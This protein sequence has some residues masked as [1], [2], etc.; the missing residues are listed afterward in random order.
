ML[1]LNITEMERDFTTVKVVTDS[2]SDIPADVAAELGI[3]V[4]PCNV[5]FGQ[6]V[7]RDGIDLTNEEFYSRLVASSELPTTSQPSAGV[8]E[9]TYRRLGSDGAAILSIHIPARVS[10]TL[11]SAHIARQALPDLSIAVVDSTQISMALGWLVIKAARAARE[12]MN[13]NRILEMVNATIPRLRLLA[14]LETLEYVYRGGR[15]G[16]AQAL[17]GT[18]LKVK[19]VIQVLNGEV[20]PIENVRTKRKALRRLIELVQALGPLEEVA[21]IHSSNAAGAREVRQMMASLHPVERIPVVEAGPVL[22]THAG[23]GAVG[24]ACVLAE[25]RRA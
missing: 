4:V 17:M 2:I 1:V 19:P 9:E 13:M 5:H 14:M 21:I 12:E 6:Q 10:G 25:T 24:I 16:K 11:N 3:T 20:L 15:I 23:P 22:G 18:L 8:F 7:Y